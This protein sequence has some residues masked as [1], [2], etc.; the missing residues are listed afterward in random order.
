[1]GCCIR[2]QQQLPA[3][4]FPM[5][6]QGAN[7]RLQMLQQQQPAASSVELGAAHA[8]IG[9]TYMLGNRFA[10]A[11]PFYDTAVKLLETAGPAGSGELKRCRVEMKKMKEN[12]VFE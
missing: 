1:M 4:Q 7:M 8:N 2:P 12:T 6:L 3:D 10:E 5:V 11:G 9:R